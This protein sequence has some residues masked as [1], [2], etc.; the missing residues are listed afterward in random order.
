MYKRNVVQLLSCDIVKPGNCI[1]VAGVSG[2]L[3]GWAH[4]TVT[5]P[6]EAAPV[7][8]VFVGT[9]KLSSVCGVVSGGTRTGLQEG[10]GSS[11]IP[12]IG[13]AC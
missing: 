12:S 1:F 7:I 10:L 9:D 13:D 8:R 5:H 4:V 6:W 3:Q 2:G 11:A